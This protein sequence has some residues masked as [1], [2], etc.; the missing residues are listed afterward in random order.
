MVMTYFQAMPIP[1]AG[2]LIKFPEGPTKLRADDRND[3]Q[4]R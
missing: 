2:A 4:H 1:Y 3:V